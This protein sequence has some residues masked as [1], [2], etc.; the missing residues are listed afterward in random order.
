L[1]NLGPA[2]SRKESDGL[3]PELSQ[4]IKILAL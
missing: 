2:S 4:A 1:I 3:P